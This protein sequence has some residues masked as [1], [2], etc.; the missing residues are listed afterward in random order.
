M[1]Q[2]DLEGE[3]VRFTEFKSAFRQTFVATPPPQILSSARILR[4]LNIETKE[5]D[6]DP[7]NASRTDS[8]GGPTASRQGGE[9]L[10]HQGLS[11]TTPGQVTLIQASTARVP[12]EQI[13]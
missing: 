10:L 5:T 6:H 11:T 9:K 12:R 1:A 3:R 4:R 8:E 13:F 7:R 2:K